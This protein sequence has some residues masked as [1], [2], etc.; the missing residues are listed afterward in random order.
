MV[1]IPDKLASMR[2]VRGRVYIVPKR[3]VNGMNI[4]LTDQDNAT[5]YYIFLGLSTPS[6]KSIG[7]V[8]NS[9]I[10][11]YI[12]QAKQDLHMPL[13]CGDG[14][15]FLAHDSFVDC[16]KLCHVNTATLSRCTCI[17]TLDSDTT[18]T[19]IGT[20]RSCGLFSVAQLREYGLL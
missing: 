12:P 3:D 7:V 20:I 13:Q 5:K 10:S 1:A 18:D 2:L 4:R 19:I 11:P 8:I 6:G 9:K 14:H 16:S 17:H 15:S